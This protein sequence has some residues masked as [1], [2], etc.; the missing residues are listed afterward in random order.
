[1]GIVLITLKVASE[2]SERNWREKPHR[3]LVDTEMDLKE[4]KAG[5]ALSPQVT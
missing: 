2:A 3:C 4:L 1:L 5:R